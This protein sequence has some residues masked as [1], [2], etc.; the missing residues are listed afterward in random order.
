MTGPD[1]D[2]NFAQFIK[3]KN[4]KENCPENCPKEGWQVQQQLDGNEYFEDKSLY[5]NAGKYRMKEKIDSKTLKIIII[6]S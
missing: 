5:I 2:G 1:V 3:H 4:C 6:I